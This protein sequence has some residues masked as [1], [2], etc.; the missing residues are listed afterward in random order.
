MS[1]KKKNKNKNKLDTREEQTEILL[2]IQRASWL[3]PVE[4]DGWAKSRTMDSFAY[5]LHYV[6]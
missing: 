3:Q 5:F 6:N 1:K 2:A 4:R